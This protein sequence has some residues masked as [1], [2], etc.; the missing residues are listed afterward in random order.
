MSKTNTFEDRLTQL[1]GDGEKAGIAKSTIAEI[2]AQHFSTNPTTIPS[3]MRQPFIGRS[4]GFIQHRN[5][6]RQH[7]THLPDDQSTKN[8]G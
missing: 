3:E 5:A 1:L 7:A 2:L 4:D 8:P 6:L